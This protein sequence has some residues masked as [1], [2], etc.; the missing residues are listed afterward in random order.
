MS[1][2]TPRYVVRHALPGDLPVLEQL[3]AEHAAYEK[4][5]PPP[6]DLA[7]RL[8]A[9]LFGAGGGAVAG[10]RALRILVAAPAGAPDGGQLAGYASCTPEFATWQGAEYLHMDCLYLRPEHRGAGVGR[11]LMAAVAEEA[12]ALGLTQLQWNT[13]AWNDGAIRFYDRTGATASPKL[14]YSLPVPS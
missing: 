4:A 12:R 7:G 13:P 2:S 1:G 14:R 6:P 9:L 8:G 10:P 3:A 11:L 5:A